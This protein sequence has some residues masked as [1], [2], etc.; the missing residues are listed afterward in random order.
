M[1]VHK[2]NL[3]VYVATTVLLPLKA[4][5]NGRVDENSNALCTHA[6]PQGRAMEIELVR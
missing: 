1:Y 3:M 2:I 5:G 4:S 6:S